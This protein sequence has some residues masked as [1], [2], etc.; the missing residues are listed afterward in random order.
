MVLRS[1]T[2][3]KTP[4]HDAHDMLSWVVMRGN[5][6]G[7]TWLAPSYLSWHFD[8]LDILVSLSKHLP[9]IFTID[10]SSKWDWE[11]FQVHLFEWLHLVALGDSCGCGVL[12]TLGGCCHLDG[13]E[14]RRSIST[15]WWLFVAG[16][17]DCEGSYTFPGGEPKCNSSGL[18]VSLSYLT[19]G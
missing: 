7:V 18:L 12:V 5:T 16:S 4:R 2:H 6:E 3:A 11:W 19:Y 14:Q 9:L 15:C 17:G 8:I 1:T 10:S 13:L